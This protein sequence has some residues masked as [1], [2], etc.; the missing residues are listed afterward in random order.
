M[1]VRM[2]TFEHNFYVTTCAG[3]TLST[4]VVVCVC[5]R[6]R[7]CVF[8]VCVCVFIYSVYNVDLVSDKN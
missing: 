6:A 2:A 1:H 3:R 5:A 7:A 4:V 8:C